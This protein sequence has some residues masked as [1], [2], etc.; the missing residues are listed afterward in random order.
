[1]KGSD[2]TN[3]TA[4]VLGLLKRFNNNEIVCISMLKKERLWQNTDGTPKSEK[5]IRRDLNII[6]AIFSESFELVRGGQHGNGCY[7]AITKKVFENFLSPKN[8]SFMAQT[9]NLAR[10]NS[11]FE[12]FDIDD[13]DKSIIKNKLKEYDKIYE[14]KN[15]PFENKINDYDLIKS[16]ENAIKY[17]KYIVIDYEVNGKIQKIEIKPYKILFMNENFY[18]ASEVEDKPYLFSPFRI[19]KI[20]KVTNTSKTFHKDYDIVDF[21]KS[22]QTPFAVYNKDYKSHLITVLLEVDSSKAEYFKS[23]KYLL[24]QEIVEEKENG[25]LVIKYEITQ[26]LEIEELIYKWMPHIKVIEPLNLKN[27]IEKQLKS[28]LKNPV[29]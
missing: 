16:L 19:S 18:L 4:R 22:I 2:M 21:I 25:N 14:F 7:K 3:Q 11:L 23:K 26:N 20:H 6:K 17:S 15:R 1:M 28:Y 8:I 27:K 13:T 29:N 12:S 24:S 10:R 9:F 5:T